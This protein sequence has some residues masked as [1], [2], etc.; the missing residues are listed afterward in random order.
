VIE[1]DL[2]V[3]GEVKSQAEFHGVTNMTKNQAAEIRQFDGTG[4]HIERYVYQ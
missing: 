3:K 2:Y 4:K 1:Q